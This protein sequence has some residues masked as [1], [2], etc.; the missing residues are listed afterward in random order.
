MSGGRLCLFWMTLALKKA[1]VWH[2][3]VWG[4]WHDIEECD[5]HNGHCTEVGSVIV[6]YASNL[7]GFL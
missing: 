1:M 7:E 5:W 4:G 6:A 2:I 3:P